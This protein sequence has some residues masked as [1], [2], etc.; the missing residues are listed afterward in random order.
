V[1]KIELTGT[2]QRKVSQ[3]ES[4]TDQELLEMSAIEGE[5]EDVSGS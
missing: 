4:L 3:L 5:F 1:K 2:Q